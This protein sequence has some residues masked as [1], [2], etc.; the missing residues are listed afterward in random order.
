M[1]VLRL[2]GFFAERPEPDLLGL[3]DLVALGTVAD[4]A[5]LLCGA[6]PI[7]IYSSSAPDQIAY[8]VSHSKARFAIVEH[9]HFLTEMLSVRDELPGRVPVRWD[10][11]EP[12]AWLGFT[13]LLWVAGGLT[14]V[15]V[16]GEFD[17]SIGSLSSHAN[18]SDRKSV[19]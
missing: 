1:R 18:G 8:L 9:E 2:R 3:L 13:P 12:T 4:V 15:L 6:T 5:A 7:S 17:L 10:G 14:L 19:V 16:V 11:Q